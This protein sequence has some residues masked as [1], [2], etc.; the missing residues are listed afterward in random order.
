MGFCCVD[1]ESLFFTEVTR[2]LLF[3]SL[4]MVSETVHLLQIA[5]KLLQTT[6]IDSV[7]ILNIC[8]QIT[9]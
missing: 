8:N 9:Y 2:L 6:Q 4:I 3:I 5:E 7:T 1:I